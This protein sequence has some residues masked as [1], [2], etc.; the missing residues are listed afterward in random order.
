ML[1]PS[2]LSDA[3]DEQAGQNPVQ[4]GF[5]SF[6]PLNF[7]YQWGSNFEVESSL[8][9]SSKASTMT[10]RHS[11]ASLGATTVEEVALHH[12]FIHPFLKKQIKN[13]FFYV[14]HLF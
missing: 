11:Q 12:L 13:V 8:N 9:S 1:G 14:F 6:T 7:Q 3:A 10:P 2:Q 5:S 4:P